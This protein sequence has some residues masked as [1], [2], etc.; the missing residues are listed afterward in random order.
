MSSIG[1]FFKRFVMNSLLSLCKGRVVKTKRG[2][3]ILVGGDRITTR[4]M[5]RKDYE[6][7]TADFIQTYL[8]A[9]DTFY[10]VGANFGFFTCLASKVVGDAGKVIAIEPNAQIAVS[11]KQNIDLNGYADR[12]T[13]FPVALSETP[14][15]GTLVFDDNASS[16][17]YLQ[18]AAD[19]SAQKSGLTVNLMTMDQIVSETGLLPKLIKIDIE[20]YEVKALNGASTLLQ[21]QDAPVI[22][23]ELNADALRRAGTQVAD[24]KALLQSHGYST[25][26]LFGQTIDILACEDQNI[27]LVPS[28]KL[29]NQQLRQSFQTK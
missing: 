16:L 10:D 9:G 19:P 13:H 4:V 20:G 29:D 22:V 5:L 18:D 1:I 25:F 26:N 12:I 7:T 3:S 24:L 23:M 21:D 27:V 17:G 14:G 28:A 15:A 8:D 2:F 11:L 6:P